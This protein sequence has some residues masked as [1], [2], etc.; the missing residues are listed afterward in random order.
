MRAGGQA[1]G[2]DATWFI[3]SAE[4]DHTSNTE[5]VETAT[6]AVCSEK[7][8]LTAG[9]HQLGLRLAHGQ[10]LC[11]PVSYGQNSVLKFLVG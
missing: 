3:R 1:P 7:L 11:A 9:A 2:S 10:S 8:G 5:N 4:S 6:N